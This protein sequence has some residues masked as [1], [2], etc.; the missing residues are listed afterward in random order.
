MGYYASGNGHI[1]FER[2][3]TDAEESALCNILESEYF[4]IWSLDKTGVDFGN[5]DT[6]DS[7][8][9]EGILRSLKDSF[10][11]LEGELEFDGEDCTHWRF[12]WR[13][14]DWREQTGRVVF[15][16]C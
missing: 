3:L 7:E 9:I 2:E 6:Y 14:G 4:D 15:E 10:P 11:I 13:D 12:L 16:D 5:Y 1:G 8:R